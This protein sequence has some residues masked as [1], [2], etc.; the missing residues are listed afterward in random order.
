MH[1]AMRD[2]IR[3][4]KVPLPRPT[5]HSTHPY[6]HKENHKLLLTY[7]QQRLWVGKES[8]DAELGRF[9]RIDKNVAGWMKMSEE[10]RKRDR[11]KAETGNP[12]AQ[13]QNL[14]LSY[15]HLDD[16]MTYFAQTFAPNRGMFYHTGKPDEQQ[17]ASQIT[18]LMNNHAIY[19]GYY[20]QVLLG[21]FSILKYNRGGYYVSWTEEIGPKLVRDPTSGTD[22]LDSQVSW[23]GN[24]LEALDMYNLLCDPLVHPT[25]LHVNGEFAAMA[26]LKSHYWLQHKASQGIYYN[27]E[28]ALKEAGQLVEFNYYKHPPR[29]AHFDLGDNT[30]SGDSSTNWVQVLSES[31]SYSTSSGYELVEIFIRL[32]PVE[33][34]LVPIDQRQAR[35]RYETWRFT[36]LNDKWIIDATYLNNVHGHIPFY[37]GLLNDDLM[38]TSQKAVSEILQPLQDFA[39]FLVNVHIASNR[40]SVWGT[41]LYDPTMVDLKQIPPGEVNARVP[42]KPAA[43]G[44]DIRQFIWQHNATLDT[45]QTLSDLTGVMDLINQF[46]PTQALPS[47]IA[48]IDRAV[49]DQVAAVQ[50]G[51]NRRQQKAA[52]LLDDSVFRNVR[53][54]MYY[55]II[56][57]QPDQTQVTD[58]YTGKQIQIDLAK[59]R[60]TDLP[61]IIGQGLKTLDRQQAASALQQIIFALI[62]A[63]QAA[64]GIDL[65]GLIDYWTGMVDIDIDM[66][67]FRLAPPT[68]VGPD[69]QPIE[70]GEAEAMA[71]AAGGAGPPIQ[72]ATNPQR[73]TRP[74]YGANG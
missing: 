70:G 60:N 3:H 21:I 5:V 43:Y 27:C 17:D 58:F 35:N 59:L 62:Q 23:R 32:N 33:F 52:R 8:R 38:G 28:D 29:E 68:Q 41:T 51:A 15:V 22:T 24:R 40:S 11:V 53:F 61:F 10:D 30:G 44:K 16:M 39:S 26:K 55:N 48:S 50:Q 66:G 18:T 36:V 6:R 64:Q 46:F 37:M 45:K 4:A 14:P 56:Q 69:G 42:V 47:Q 49:S 7:L 2:K 25:E 9:V 65:L 34:G 54:S 71:A 12:V 13:N 1:D 31:M 72:P 73:L 20:R 19:S 74:I 57:Y 63:P 67:Q